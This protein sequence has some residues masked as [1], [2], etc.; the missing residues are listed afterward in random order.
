MKTEAGRIVKFR[1]D[2]ANAAII[3]Q[4]TLGG[5]GNRVS[6]GDVLPAMIVSVS[7]EADVVNLHVFVDG[8]KDHWITGVHQGTSEGTWNWPVLTQDAHLGA[9]ESGVCVK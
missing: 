1:C 8:P 9:T 5:P 6:A 3:N 2:T 4:R 7:A